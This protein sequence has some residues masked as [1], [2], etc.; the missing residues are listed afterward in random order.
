VRKAAARF[1]VTCEAPLT[2]PLPS[3]LL[4]QRL[5]EGTTLVVDRY[6]Y[7]GVAFTA[8]KQAAGLDLEW[9]K[10]R[11]SC[12]AAAA[13]SAPQAPDRGL[14]SPDAVLLLRLAPE[15]AAARG[16]FGAE[17]YETLELQRRVAE[18]FEA[19]RA[20]WWT[21]VDAGRSEAEVA[22]EVE[23]A[24]AAAV[25]RAAAGV[26]LGSLWDDRRAA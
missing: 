11:R 4:E 15:A 3:A 19:L 18:H 9:C 8:A 25:E 2:Q 26:P 6:A 14:P 1:G 7:S 16:A 21:L 5:R 10:A 13:L 17:R 23:A 24:A 12:S 22:A 20:P